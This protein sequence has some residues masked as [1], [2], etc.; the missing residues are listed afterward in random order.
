M[1]FLNRPYF[2][3][4]W[5]LTLEEANYAPVFIADGFEMADITREARFPV[6]LRGRDRA[7]PR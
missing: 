4:F 3:H 5:M 6:P 1:I 2:R 7:L